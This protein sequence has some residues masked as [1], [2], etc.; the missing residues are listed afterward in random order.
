M[1][2]PIK[3]ITVA[4]GL[5]ALVLLLVSCTKDPQ[6]A[7][8]KYLASGENYMKKGQFGD[9]AVEFQNAIRLDPRSADAYYQLAQAE[10]GQHDGNAAYQSLE[11]AFALDQSRLDVRLERGRLYLAARDFQQ[12]EEQA[13][14]I[15]EHEQNNVAAYQLLGSSFIG[16]QQPDKA[17]PQFEKVMELSPND[18]GSYVNV[19]LVEISLGRYQDA[20]Q[21]FKKAVSVDPKSIQAYTDLANFYRMTKPKRESEA[22]LVLQEAIARNPEGAPLYLN[23]AS[24]L[25]SQG[26][27]EDAEGVL[28]RLRK[29]V[30]NSADIARDIGDF[31]FQNKELDRALSEY[32]RGLSI[33]PKNLEIKKRMQDLYLTTGQ[34]QLAAD[35]DQELM[36]DTPKDT[37]VRI[38]H[39]RLLMAQGNPQNAIVYLQKVVADAT[40]SAEA[41][42]YLAMAYSQNGEA[43][44]AHTALIDTLKASPGLPL[45]LEA[46]ARL[47]MAQDRPADAQV[48]ANELKERFPFEPRYRLLLAEA[49]KDQDQFVLAQ[50]EILIAMQ[51]APSDPM[52]HLN[53]AEIYS[54]QKK[55]PEAQKEFD[56]ALKLDPNNTTLL[57]KYT[58]YLIDR[59][60]FAQALIHVR[61]YLNSNPNDANGHVILGYVYYDSKNYT[62]AQTEFER[63]IQLDQ[64]N[65]QAYLRLGKLFEDEGQIDLAI[66]RY[67]KSLEL[68]PRSAP[69]ATMVGNFYLNKGDLA[70]A[71]KYYNQ[72]LGADPN[73][74][75]A[76]ANIAWLDAEEGKD[77]DSALGMAQ[78]AKS[79]E[80]DLLSITD[81]LGWVLYKRG[82]YPEAIP[83][84]QDCVNKS[85]DSAEFRFHLGMSL[86]ANG[87]EAK[88]KEQLQ[89]A[90]RMNLRS[91]DAQQA[92]LKLSQT[93]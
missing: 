13:N 19:A 67:Q 71:R 59:N 66:A 82:S 89:T 75:I 81:T 73:F 50:K 6:K 60:Q 38:D 29:Q 47:S 35:L 69:L 26:R 12:A 22:E 44:Q 79:L 31:Y 33:S 4:C 42:Y 34:T 39:G 88:G 77:L 23:L 46:L 16:Q 17:L 45:A 53:L 5:I 62:A 9:A 72:A 49:L 65:V 86:L 3:R 70:T 11:K 48:Y 10:L 36:K 28:E 74:P 76:I 41:H 1:N 43:D 54:A 83:L 58:D 18:P 92:R 25:A 52:I 55:W 80:P 40:D 78:K 20:E 14:F 87:Q 32:R 64:T 90:L 8:E 57:G 2:S 85:P 7:K 68:Q 63:A 51:L 91:V 30:P 21:H 37:I 15:I 56:T 27:R 84:L 61:E 93:N 24:M